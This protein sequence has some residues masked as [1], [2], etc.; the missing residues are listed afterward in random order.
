MRAGARV[1]KKEVWH[2]VT[3]NDRS[4]A[5][6]WNMFHAQR[7]QN[8]TTA[9]VAQGDTARPELGSS[10]YYSTILRSGFELVDQ[11]GNVGVACGRQAVHF[12]ATS[13][14]HARR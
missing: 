14:P 10:R 8:L 9:K 13:K 5:N 1:Q 6:L 4:F 11:S 3:S 2:G 12:E 7:C